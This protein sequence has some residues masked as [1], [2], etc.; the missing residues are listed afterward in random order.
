[1]LVNW[2][3]VAKELARDS[4]AW[5]ERALTA[6]RHLASYEDR[7]RRQRLCCC[8]RPH[9]HSG[10]DFPAYPASNVHCPLCFYHNNKDHSDAPSR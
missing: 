4:V 2:F 8:D 10:V 5:R 6:E 7:E 9:M 1:M 3:E